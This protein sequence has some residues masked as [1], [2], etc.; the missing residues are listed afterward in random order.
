MNV[1]I[2]L[3][4]STCLTTVVIWTCLC[5]NPFTDFS[6]AIQGLCWTHCWTVG[7]WAKTGRNV[8]DTLGICRQT[9]AVMHQIWITWRRWSVATF[10][11]LIVYC[12]SDWA[13]VPHLNCNRPLLRKHAWLASSLSRASLRDINR[14]VKVQVF[15]NR[16]L[17]T[18]ESS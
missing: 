18:S 12:L 13:E 14:W 9:Y 11:P 7:L 1:D 3:T 6:E 17:G 8:L 10:Y 16:L 15:T 4:H 5:A 2:D